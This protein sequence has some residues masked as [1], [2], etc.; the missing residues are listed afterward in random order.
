MS[1]FLTPYVKKSLILGTVRTMDY[2]S[3]PIIKLTEEKEAFIQ[4]VIKE[5]SDTLIKSSKR[6][7]HVRDLIEKTVYQ[8]RIRIKEIPWDVDPKD[9]EKYWSGVK[10]SLLDI[11]SLD[12]QPDKKSEIEKELLKNIINR[13]VRQTVGNFTLS[14]YKFS[15]FVVPILFNRLL[16]SF[17]KGWFRGPFSREQVIQKKVELKG[18]IELIKKL[19]KDHTLVLV[20]THFSNLDSVLLGYGIH[21]AGLPPFIYGA[22]LNLYNNRLVAYFIDRLG[23]YKLD[24]RKKNNI[25][26]ETLKSF[27]KVALQRG[28]HTLFFPGGTRSR[29]GALEDKLKLGLLSTLID[30]QIANLLPNGNQKKIVVIPV[31]IGY[32]FVLEAPSL[33]RDYLTK[34]GKERYYLDQRD[35]IASR[36]KLFK[37]VGNFF[38]KGSNIVLSFGKPMD[39]LG[40]YVVETGESIDPNLAQLSNEATRRQ[41]DIT[42]YFITQNTLKH[43][44]QR[45]HEYTKILGTR[46]VEEYKRTNIVLASHTISFLAFILLKKRFKNLDLY[47]LLRLNEEDRTLNYHEFA[48]HLHNFQKTL[49]QYA[50]KGL[51]QLDETFLLNLDEFMKEG[52]DNLGIFHAS[53]VLYINKSGYLTTEDMNLLYF[54]HNRLTGYELEQYI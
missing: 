4:Q 7:D 30:A 6:S 54:Y 31:V 14:T 36:F 43:I 24:R 11:I 46:I 42:K 50:S 2:E 27:S 41:I 9:E 5:S 29:S 38:S 13:Y 26:L 12:E 16:N 10:K 3:W 18:N 23:A 32:N 17:T 47:N 25:Y 48:E 35:R 53:K 33:A 15:I 37:L 39:V 40:N 21:M 44:E 1:D 28:C 8:E 52:L 19:E 20:P 49:K 22:G 45:D 51:L 34:T